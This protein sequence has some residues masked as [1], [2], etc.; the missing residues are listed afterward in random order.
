MDE[1]EEM[2]KLTL[3]DFKIL[4]KL[5]SGSFGSVYLVCP[6]KQEKNLSKA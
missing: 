4:D 6:K 1:E 2:K 3:K 5:G